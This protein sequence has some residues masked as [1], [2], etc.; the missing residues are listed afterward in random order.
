[1]K[2]LYVEKIGSLLRD[3][4]EKKGLSLEHVSSELKINP[5]YL[6]ALEE[7]DLNRI[8][9]IIFAKGFLKNYANYLGLDGDRLVYILTR[10]ILQE[11]QFS[12][13]ESRESVIREE[14][15]KKLLR[16]LFLI[17]LFGI[18]L[19]SWLR[20]SHVNNQRNMEIEKRKTTNFNTLTT[21][22]ELALHEEKKKIIGEAENITDKDLVIIKASQDCWVEAVFEGNKI[23]QGLLLKGDK[24]ELPY[25]KGMKIKFGNIGGIE[26][27][28]KGE[29]KKELGRDGEVKEIVIE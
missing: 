11:K 9:A 4:R 16:N 25:R 24:K 8:P 27:V 18:I 6:T 3:A 22:K 26:L 12:P 23:Y 7:G 2:E 19:F 5:D 1:M 10:E 29:T 14:K 13:V 21:A 15:N 20:V 28:I 17:C